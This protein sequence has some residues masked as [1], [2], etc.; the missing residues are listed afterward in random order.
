MSWSDIPTCK[1]QG[2][3]IEYQMLRGM[4]LP[5]KVTA[6][7]TAFYVDLFKRSPRRLNTRSTW[8]TRR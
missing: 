1:E 6:D 5:G 4:F 7:Q 3:D 8:K 2:V